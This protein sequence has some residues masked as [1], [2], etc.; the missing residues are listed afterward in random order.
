MDETPQAGA[1]GAEETG[2]DAAGFLSGLSDE[3]RALALENDWQGP[4]SILDGYRSLQQKLGTAIYLPGDKADP[5]EQAAFY[6]DLAKSWTPET[7]YQFK[8]PE[9]LPEDFP[10]DQTFAEEAGGWFREAGLHPDAAQK[11]H[12]RWLGKMSEQFAAQQSDVSEAAQAQAEAVERAHQS[13]VRDYGDP[14][15][16]RYQNLVAKADRAL[17]SLKASGVDLT[18]WFAGKGALTRADENGLQQVADPTAVKLLAVIHDRTLA[19][20]SLADLGETGSG[21]NPFDTGNPDLRRQSELLESNPARARQM[22][23]SAGRDPKLF[24]L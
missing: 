20:D 18:D 3:N 2:A 5:E 22:I 16:D 12:D 1:G 10:Y 24:R 23:V 15:G 21:S 19:E 9:S 4:D 8:L 7:G 13:L 11:L 14:A 6:Q 17:S